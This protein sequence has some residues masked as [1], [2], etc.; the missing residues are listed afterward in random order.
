MGKTDSFQI[1]LVGLLLRG[2][3]FF[4]SIV[5]LEVSAFE[6]TPVKVLSVYDG[7]TITVAGSLG[8]SEYPVKVRLLYLDTPEVR[9]NKHGAAMPE[10]KQAR[11]YLREIL[12][13]GIMVKLWCPGDELKR[14]G[15]GRVLA[16]VLVKEKH[17]LH[18]S[19]SPTVQM[20][21][22]V[23]KLM[24]QSGYSVYW[25]KY[26]DCPDELRHVLLKGAH[27]EAKSA[28]KGIWGTNWKWMVDKSNERTAGK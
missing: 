20:W 27:D 25:R 26:G 24:I 14:D 2:L 19:S 10:G 18:I 3:V 16:M 7:D 17:K 6:T 23:N 13:E 9:G 1:T 4:L 5:V 28:R 22:N 8:G 21:V 11:D 15:Y 12:P